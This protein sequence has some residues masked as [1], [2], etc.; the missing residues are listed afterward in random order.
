MALATVLASERDPVVPLVV[1]VQVFP[2][3]KTGGRQIR[4]HS[5]TAF[6]SLLFSFRLHY[7]FHVCVYRP[8]QMGFLSAISR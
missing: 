3:A 5:P 1:V 6:A 7:P 4:G 8:D 2:A